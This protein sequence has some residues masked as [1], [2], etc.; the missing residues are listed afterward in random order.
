MKA[1]AFT[2]LHRGGEGAPLLL[3]HGFTDTWRTWELTLPS[4]E[5]D[6]DVLAPTL[7]GHAGGPPLPRPLTATTGVEFL[8]S[9]LDEAGWERPLVAGNS[10][11]GWLALQLA[12]RGRARA[13]VAFAPAGDPSSVEALPY[14]RTMHRLVRRAAPA[15]DRIAS[16]DAGRRR[17]TRD[18]TVRYEHIPAELLV[19]QLVG[20]ARC[21]ATLPLADFAERN[22]WPLD[23]AA[24]DCPV[25]IV[26]GLDDAILRWPRAA[27]RYRRDLPQADWVELD[28]V[29]HA[30]QLDVPAVVA[31]LIRALA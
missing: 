3:V 18:L 29:G 28:G 21:E 30:P 14:F 7:P 16:T 24:I 23:A 15:A 27:E 1:E 11:G 17:M 22:G 26:W 2:P 10:L 5:R 20:A 6:F 25:R 8:E 12:S 13:V 4:L 31:D 19:H 9:V